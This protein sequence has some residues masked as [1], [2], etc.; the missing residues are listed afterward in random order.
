MPQLRRELGTR[1]LVLTV[2]TLLAAAVLA[3][4]V[5][6]LPEF[7]V[8]RD[9]DEDGR[10]PLTAAELLEAKNNVRTTLL[11][12]LA[13]AVLLL[14]AYL[15]WRQIQVT[16]EGQMQEAHLNREGQI[17]ERFTRAVEQLGSDKLSVRVGGIY[18]LERIARD[19]RVDHGPV[20]EVLTAFLREPPS[21]EHDNF[22]EERD[23]GLRADLQAAATVIGRRNVESDTPNRY[24][25]L[26]GARL[27]RAA[28][29]RSHLLGARLDGA[30]LTRANLQSANLVG[31]SLRGAN[32]VSAI[33]QLA[34]FE[35]AFCAGADLREADFLG[36][37]FHGASL[38]DTDLRGASLGHA[39]LQVADLRGANLARADLQHAQLVGAY[40]EKADL[41]GADL[42]DADMTGANLEGADLRGADLSGASLR[43]ALGV[44]GEQIAQAVIDDSTELTLDDAAD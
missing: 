39:K 14:G 12:G 31:A 43:G 23:H 30:R 17:T 28:L 34:N 2:L 25:N 3:G 15:T 24:L 19:S 33:A 21:A 16:R 4:I 1:R 13:G 38:A 7:V 18:A 5:F 35:S 32:L 10:K 22:A 6:L 8:R 44:T 36:A 37:N 27:P 26:T 40:L 41:S 9:M 20:M 29:I 11:Q 42:T